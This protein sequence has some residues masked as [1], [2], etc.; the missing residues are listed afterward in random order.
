MKLV[1]KNIVISFYKGMQYNIKL[2]HVFWFPISI[3]LIITTKYKKV[4]NY[5]FY[6]HRLQ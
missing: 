6:I 1:N 4:N 2:N 5:K 3:V